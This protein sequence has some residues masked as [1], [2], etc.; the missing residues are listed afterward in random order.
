MAEKQPLIS[1]IVPVYKVELYLRKC[2]D[3]IVNQTYKNL[4]ILLIDDASPDRCGEI[5]EEYASKDKRIRVFH[6]KVNRGLSAARNRGLVEATGEYI[7]FV[8]SDDWIESDMYEMLVQMI[9]EADIAVCGYYICNYTRTYIV[10][11]IEK[12]TKSFF[13]GPDILIAL[14]D[15]EIDNAIWNKLYRKEI[16]ER[17]RFPED[18]SFEDAAIMHKIVEQA[19]G[20]Y[21]YSLPKYHYQKRENSITKINTAKNLIDFAD[22]HIERYCFFEEKHRELFKTKQEKVTRYAA[23]GIAKTWRWWFGC[24]NQEKQKYMGK[25]KDFLTFTRENIPLFGYHAW[26]IWL[27]ITVFFAH[28]KCQI[29]FAVLFSLN[30]L[31]RTIGLRKTDVM[32]YGKKLIVDVN[33]KAG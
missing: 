29:S 25:I 17:I 11:Y 26:P 27:K 5:C 15:N 9:D 30:R 31:L 12:H 13:S 32:H 10:G 4:E 3:S 22:A 28:S 1:I 7:G 16:F 21:V 20:V 8:D 33:K 24:S 23:I 2:L 19:K 14:L 6:N 18:R